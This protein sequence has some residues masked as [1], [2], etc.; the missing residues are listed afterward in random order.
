MQFIPLPTIPPPTPSSF[1]SPSL[2]S[3][4][5]SFPPCRRAPF[6][7]WSSCSLPSL[8]SCP[9]LSLSSCPLP[10]LSSC[11]LPP[12][13]VAVATVCLATAAA[14]PAAR[15][16]IQ[17]TD[18]YTVAAAVLQRN[19]CST[20]SCQHVHVG[21]MVTHTMCS[22]THH[23]W[24]HRVVSFCLCYYSLS[25]LLQSVSVAAVCLCCCSLSLLL[26]SVC[27]AAVCLYCLMLLMFDEYCL[28]TDNALS[29]V[30]TDNALSGVYTD[31]ALSGVFTDNALS[32][33]FTDNALLG[34]FTD[35]AL[36]GVFTD[37]ALSGV[38]T[39]NALSG[40]YTDNALSGV[41][42]DNHVIRHPNI[43]V[44]PRTNNN[45]QEQ[46]QKNTKQATFPNRALLGDRLLVP[47]ESE[48]AA[49]CKLQHLEM[50]TQ[51]CEHEHHHEGG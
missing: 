20:D 24:H 39:D 2:S 33:V 47:H 6:L 18:I 32:G 11:P 14:A 10:S 37:N 34:V 49:A 36:S 50:K 27:I 1:R 41:F 3:R 4:R 5:A 29:G 12:L 43:F 25:L 48:R 21:D 13:V 15:P 8:S 17:A 46:N 38:F 22:R 40:V 7:L 35:N 9:L 45:Q 19:S 16:T 42:T 23:T 26:Q 51:Q 31:N 44:V 30:F 28:Y